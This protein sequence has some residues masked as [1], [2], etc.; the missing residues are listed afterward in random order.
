MRLDV[1]DEEAV[2]E[3]REAYN[4]LESLMHVAEYM[5]P[6]TMAAIADAL[7]RVEV[8]QER[9]REGVRRAQEQE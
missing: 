5:G 1:P 2:K 4:A 6:G 7:S 3:W 9:A 8:A